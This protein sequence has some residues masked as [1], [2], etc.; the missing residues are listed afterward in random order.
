ASSAPA[1]SLRVSVAEPL[2]VS[3]CFYHRRI[4]RKTRADRSSFSRC[5]AISAR[6]ACSSSRS[7][8]SDTTTSVNAN[9]VLVRAD[10]RNAFASGGERRSNRLDV[11]E[12]D[13]VAP[14]PF[15]VRHAS[16]RHRLERAAEPAAALTRVLRD[17][18]LL[19]AIARQEDDNAIRFTELVGPENQRVAGV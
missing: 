9:G 11:V 7:T 5:R 2:C 19:A 18:A 13:Q 1:L 6:C 3:Q 16:R 15:E 10:A 14:R 17:A 8:P 12:A 4:S